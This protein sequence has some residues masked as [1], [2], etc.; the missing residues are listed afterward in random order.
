MSVD[1]VVRGMAAA[2]RALRLDPRLEDA[3]VA[4]GTLLE[5]RNPRSLDGVL[6]SYQK[7]LTLIPR[8][9]EALR[10]LARATAYMGNF[11]LAEERYRRALAAGTQRAHVLC[12]LADLAYIE[13]KAVKAKRLLDSAS[14]ADP[15]I[16]D[17][18]L[19]RVRMLLR[20]RD[21]RDAWVDAELAARLGY[22]I[23]GTALSILVWA[24]MPDSAATHARADSLAR[25]ARRSRTVLPV[26]DARY[27]ALTF[28]AIGKPVPALEALERAYP[29]GASLWLAMQDPGLG[30]LAGQPR[31]RS[32]IKQSRATTR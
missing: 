19:L 24:R 26:L 28:V 21:F 16:G 30:P 3:W 6:R 15:A 17:A 23:P 27:V 14:A 5:Y 25:A 11:E 12:D 7:A 22:P 1:A 20:R 10:R 8:D 32:L 13:R 31:F 18:H 29:R 9:A 2:D 4:R